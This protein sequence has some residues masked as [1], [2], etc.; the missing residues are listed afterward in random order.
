MRGLI[1]PEGARPVW[2]L[3]IIAPSATEPRYVSAL[4]MAP[5][6]AAGLTP[7]PA[8]SGVLRPGTAV[9]MHTLKSAN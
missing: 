6:L 5:A 2:H 4:K 9:A 1:L 3:L 8:F 7:C